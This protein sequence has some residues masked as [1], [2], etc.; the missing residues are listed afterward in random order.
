MLEKDARKAYEK[1]R[2]F[3]PSDIE[4]IKSALANLDS[5]KL[6]KDRAK[7]LPDLN[8][9]FKT[10]GFKPD[11]KQMKAIVQSLSER[12]QTAEICRDKDGNP[13]PDTELRDNE[14]VP[15]RS[16]PEKDRNG[17]N[18]IDRETIDEYFA[19]EVLPHVSD[20]W[21]DYSKTKIGYEINFTKYFY[22]YK[23]LRKLAEIRAD[24]L[25]LEDETE[26]MIKAVIV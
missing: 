19:R 9:A 18:V 14:N 10:E 7:F 24:I 8:R 20:A 22:K 16:V 3:S 17:E 11:S 2:V 4:S 6:Y 1:K 13:E 15:L 25:A 26:G 21:I 23:P 5:N 12:D